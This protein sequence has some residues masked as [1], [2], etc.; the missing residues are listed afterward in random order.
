M[1]LSMA[2]SVDEFVIAF[3]TAGRRRRCRWSS[4]DDPTGIDPRLNAIGDGP[5]LATTGLAFTGRPPDDMDGPVSR[6]RRARSP[7]RS[8]AST[9]LRQGAGG[10]D[11]SLDVREGEFFSLLGPRGCGKTTSLRMMA[12]LRVARRRGA[13]CCAART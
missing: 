5:A 12:G 6:S 13:S 7:S 4:T 9:A 1:L 10:D 3:F 8:T 11:L 2:I